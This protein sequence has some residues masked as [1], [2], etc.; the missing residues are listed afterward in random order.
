MTTLIAAVLLLLAAITLHEVFRKHFLAKVAQKEASIAALMENLCSLSTNRD[1]WKDKYVTSERALTQLKDDITA[2][3]IILAEQAPIFIDTYKRLE[4]ECDC[5]FCR[6]L[7]KD[8]L[9]MSEGL[10][11]GININGKPTIVECP[12]M[13]FPDGGIVEV[14]DHNIIVGSVAQPVT[15]E[16]TEPELQSVPVVMAP[17]YAPGT[18]P[19]GMT[20]AK[21]AEEPTKE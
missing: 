2:V 6:E 9:D 4:H 8:Y 7:F 21:D 14:P 11:V 5:D 19:T 17:V 13:S 12:T 18:Y 3:V 15:V 10:T 20:P 1:M 16:A